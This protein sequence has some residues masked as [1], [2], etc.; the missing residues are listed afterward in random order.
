[1][2]PDEL[3]SVW[4]WV[5]D[6]V[7]AGAVMPAGALATVGFAYALRDLISPLFLDVFFTAVIVGGILGALLGAPAWL[8]ARLVWRSGVLPAFA[9]GPVMGALGA[10][11]ALWGTELAMAGRS[12]AGALLAMAAFGA[13]SVGPPW[14]AYLSVRSRGRSGMAVV[15]GSG[16][17]AAGCALMLMGWME[18]RDML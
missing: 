16:L 6:A 8:A 1:M 10:P 15:L 17:W 9:M 3:G 13:V 5:R 7:L 4:S 2:P 12:S 18:L 11:L 14:V